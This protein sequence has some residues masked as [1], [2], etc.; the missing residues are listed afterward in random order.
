MNSLNIENSVSIAPEADILAFVCTEEEAEDRRI[1]DLYWAIPRDKLAESMARHPAG[2]RML[3]VQ[4][5]EQ[6]GACLSLVKSID[7][8]LAI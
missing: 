1:R 5:V 2:R 6:A 8:P 4:A 3:A 7:E